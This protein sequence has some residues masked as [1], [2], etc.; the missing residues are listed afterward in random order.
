MSPN[1]NNICNM[2]KLE[3]PAAHQ[4]AHLRH[5]NIVT[6]ESNGEDELCRKKESKKAHFKLRVSVK[7][8]CHAT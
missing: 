3:R 8:G 4:V 6:S 5:S 1:K 7:L 2:T